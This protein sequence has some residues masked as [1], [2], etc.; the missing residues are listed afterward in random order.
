MLLYHQQ[1]DAGINIL[2]TNLVLG[3]KTLG[4]DYVKFLEILGDVYPEP[5]WF[6]HIAMLILIVKTPP[7]TKKRIKYDL[8]LEW[9]RVILCIS[10]WKNL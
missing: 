7:P 10:S 9:K 5:Y 3:S 6:S 2:Q 8:Y 1:M 4:Y